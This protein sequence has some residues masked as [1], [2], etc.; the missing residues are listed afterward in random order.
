MARRVINGPLFPQ[1]W[2]ELDGEVASAEAEVLKAA[3]QV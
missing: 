2:I 3:G 1:S